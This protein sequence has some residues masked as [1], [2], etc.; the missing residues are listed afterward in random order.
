MPVVMMAT[1]TITNSAVVEVDGIEIPE[2]EKLKV[3]DTREIEDYDF[4]IVGAGISGINM[5]YRFQQHFPKKSYVVLEQR[6]NMGGT[7]DLMRYPGI[8]SDSDLHTFGFA[9]RPW[10]EKV[11]IAEGYKI[12]RYMKESASMY[13]IDKKILYRHKIREANWNSR[14]Q[15]W[16]LTAEV[17]NTDGSKKTKFFRAPFLVMGTG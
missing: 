9:W 1:E 6:E 4:L 16:T 7:W 2:E 14:E 12:L 13:G 10:E 8:R 3:V 11:P 5:S 15:A 17:T